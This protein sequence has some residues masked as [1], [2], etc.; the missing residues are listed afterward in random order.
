M[1]LSML[2]VN[3][4]INNKF[5]IKNLIENIS[6]EEISIFEKKGIIFDETRKKI[7]KNSD[8]LDFQAVPGSGKTTLLVTKLLLIADKWDFKNK[9]ICVLSHTN[10][11]KDE[12]YK[13]INESGIGK[14]LLK[15]PHFI[16]T[17]QGFV[18]KY[19]GIPAIKYNNFNFSTVDS[20]FYNSYAKKKLNFKARNYLDR[21][22][23]TNLYGLK[24]EFK[25]EELILNVPGFGKF[26]RN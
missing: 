21:K 4:M 1:L 26:V 2:L 24:L 18:D 12:I 10:V 3:R 13:K 5:I 9:G 19:L 17:I 8:S 25:N 11:A 7:I 6:D 14:N 23:V 16:G 20:E 22:N 15:Y